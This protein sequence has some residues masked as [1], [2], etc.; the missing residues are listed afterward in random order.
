MVAPQIGRDAALARARRALHDGEAAPAHIGA[1]QD[2]AG[3][4]VAAP[5]MHHHPCRAVRQQPLRAGAG[6]QAP[7]RGRIHEDEVQRDVAVVAALARQVGGGDAF[8]DGPVPARLPRATQRRIK[9]AIDQR[10]TL[11]GRDPQPS[12]LQRIARRGQARKGQ[13]L[14]AS[15][16]GQGRR[17]RARDPWRG[18]RGAQDGQ[19][20]ASFHW[21]PPYL[22]HARYARPPHAVAVSRQSEA[23]LR[24]G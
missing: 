1:G 16:K 21:V 9:P 11:I 22:S 4:V 8:A 17:L 18:Q 2:A 6:A 5:D 10:G 13:R 20:H 3:G 19:G 7:G 12:A 23:G 14:P 24:E 15:V